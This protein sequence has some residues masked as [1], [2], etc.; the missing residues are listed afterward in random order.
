MSERIYIAGPYCPRGCNL[1][2]AARIAQHNV[3]EAIEVANA[4]IEKGHFVFVP[5]LSHYIHTHYSSHKDRG[6]WWYLEDDTF[7]DHWA[8]AFFYIGRSPGADAEL[9]KAKKLGLKIYYYFVEVPNVELER[10]WR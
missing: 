10:R 1:H 4:L 3:D 9:D 7:L 8:T 5:H 6:A 2:D